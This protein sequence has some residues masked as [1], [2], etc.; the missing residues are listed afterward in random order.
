MSKRVLIVTVAVLVG[1][2]A[3]SPVS[4]TRAS[5][6]VIENFD[7][8]LAVAMP[9]DF[10]MGSLMRANCSRLVRVEQPDGTAIE[11]QTCQLSSEPVMIPAFQGAPPERAFRLSGGACTWT[12]DYWWRVA[13]SPVYAESFSYVVSPG[14]TVRAIS[15]YPA[16]PL[17]CG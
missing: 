2:A 12:S 3:A 7:T 9:Q 11:T 17:S 5:V 1:L 10:P 6:G 15:T 16:D 13:D 8:V 4:A 14:G